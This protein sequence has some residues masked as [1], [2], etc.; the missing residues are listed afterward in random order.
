MTIYISER[1][2]PISLQ[3]RL[4]CRVAAA[5]RN[6]KLCQLH[7][8]YRNSQQMATY[9]NLERQHHLITFRT[10]KLNSEVSLLFCVKLCNVFILFNVLFTMDKSIH[11][12]VSSKTEI[13]FYLAIIFYKVFLDNF[14]TYVKQ[15]RTF[16][17]RIRKV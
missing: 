3:H 11:S 13:Q 7:H 16:F 12:F 17:R 8:P 15:M 2:Q 14:L 6:T 10:H 1:Y 5:H 9:K 4:W